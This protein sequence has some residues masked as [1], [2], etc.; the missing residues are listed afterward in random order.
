MNLEKFYDEIRDTFTLTDENV[1][2]F[3]FILRYAEYEYK[4]HLDELAYILATAWHETAHRMQPI[5]EYGKGRGRKYGKSTPPFGK[6]YYGRGYVQLTWDYNY[7]KAGDKLGVDFLRYPEK[8]M[9][10][11]HAVKILFVGMQQGWF[12]GKKLRDYLDNV[13]ENDKEDLREFTNA[14]RII[15]GTDKQVMIGQY[16]LVFEKALRAAGYGEKQTA[17]E[18]KKPE[19]SE[20]KPTLVDAILAILKAIFKK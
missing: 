16:A 1:R 8:V 3:D 20:K 6:V 10:P 9:E 13:D 17:P 15:N 18:K 11:E 14:R 4:P 12:T 2:G 7:K 5:A 19:P